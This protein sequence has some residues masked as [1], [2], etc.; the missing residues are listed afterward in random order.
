MLETYERFTLVGLIYQVRTGLYRV[1]QST[2]S[3]P[4][5][6]ER[7]FLVG[8]VRLDRKGL[9]SILSKD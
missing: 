4:K 5:G 1:I 8:A 9:L 2:A 7:W 3:E 6:I